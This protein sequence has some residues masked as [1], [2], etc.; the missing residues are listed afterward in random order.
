MFYV[1]HLNQLWRIWAS[2]SLALASFSLMATTQD[3][4]LEAALDRFLQLSQTE[5]AQAKALLEQLYQHEITNAAIESRARLL[6][7]HFSEQPLDA[8]SNQTEL[9]HALALAQSSDNSNV[10]VEI[11]AVEL[12]YLQRLQQ[13]N[14]AFIKAEQLLPLMDDVSNPRL[15][16]FANAVLASLY[17]RDNQPELALR[18]FNKAFDALID[19]TD[20]RSE[21][22]R[23]AIHRQIAWLHTEMKNLVK[24]REL[25]EQLVVQDRQQQN[26]ASLADDFLLLGYV[27]AEQHDSQTALEANLKGMQV[28]EQL[29]NQSLSLTFKNNLGSTY[30]QLEQYPQAKDILGQALLIAQHLADEEN[31]RFILFNL[32]Y[33]EVMEGNKAGLLKMRQVVEF[34]QKNGPKTE[35]ES[36]LEWLAKAYAAS[37]DYQQQA[38]ALQQRL[39]L[40]AE[41]LTEQR[42]KTLSDLQIRFDTKAKN[43]QITILQQENALQQEL[44]KNRQLQQR[45]SILFA[46]VMVFGAGLLIA[47]Y[48]KV[49]RSNKQLKRVN[50][51]LEI[52]SKRDPLTGL[53]NRRALQEFMAQ[54]S[55]SKQP[56]ACG[57]LLMDI[58]FFKQIND[59][60]GHAAGDE[61]LIELSQRLTTLCRQDDLLIRWG[62]EE[63]VLLVCNSSTEYLQEVASRLLL[64]VSATPV[65]YA[66]Q[67]IQVDLSGGMIQLP[68]AG[69]DEKKFHWEKAMQLADMALYFSKLHGR[70][71]MHFI[72]GLTTDFPQAEP[73]LSTDLAAALA[74]NMID[75][76]RITKSSAGS[77]PNHQNGGED[78]QS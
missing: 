29:A 69:V 67:A 6:S 66:G 35:F 62:G 56:K 38:A 44:L 13:F 47:L 7:Y 45:V 51:Q 28:A 22:R 3:P 77:G 23:N 49:R 71:Q 26:L 43:Q 74:E 5:P 50:Q 32:A 55:T 42:D 48:R 10:K 2:C 53:L 60:Y 30:I 78:H 40:R 21:L 73:Y 36:C 34:Y 18:Y 4:Q 46:V 72:R 14:L 8:S 15:K 31:S 27:A 64:L 70:Q 39:D 75:L 19:K 68:F 25:A 76:V 54:R 16:Y 65:D 37:G 20:Q 12:D 11:Y 33:I 1:S 52:Q 9:E 24:A 61:V 41:L 59:K 17:Q 63:F 57:I 58:D